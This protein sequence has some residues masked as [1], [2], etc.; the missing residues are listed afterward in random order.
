MLGEITHVLMK[1]QVIFGT[2]PGWWLSK[3]LS[4]RHH[5]FHPYF[6]IY[7]FFLQV[8]HLCAALWAFHPYETIGQ[9]DGRKWGPTL[10][11]TSWNEVLTCQGFSGIDLSLRDYED[12][13]DYS[14]S[15]IV[16]TAPQ[17]KTL[18][19]LRDIIIVGPLVPSPGL[20]TLSSKLID[21]LRLL[22]LSTTIVRFEDLIQQDIEGKICIILLEVDHPILHSIQHA[23]FLTVKRLILRSANVL[24]ITRGGSFDSPVP[25]A[26]LITGLAR[27]I[28]AE[29][30]AISLVTLD[31]DFKTPISADTNAKCILRLFSSPWN[32]ESPRVPDLKYA[33]KE[34]L[35]S[36]LS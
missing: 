16:S 27:T 7:F 14:T 26:N 3:F 4:L 35:H 5:T 1:H 9:D 22:G 32:S 30:S 34:G 18:P 28:R 21:E 20:Q 8:L 25:E 15:L 17:I 11:E 2:L 6:F 29:N 23:E 13:K 19:F 12:L 24:W 10:T 36:S 33:S 31:L